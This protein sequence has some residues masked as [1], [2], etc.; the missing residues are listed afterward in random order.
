MSIDSVIFRPN[1]IKIV[2]SGLDNAGKSSLLIVMNKM[3]QFEEDLRHL[4]P[5]VRID[6]YRRDFL[7]Y[8]L[9]FWDFGGQ[10]KYRERYLQ[11]KVYFE[12][13]NQFIY[14][15]DIT[16]PNRV[17]ESLEYLGQILEILNEVGYDKSKELYIC[18]S[19]MDYNAAFSERPEYIVTLANARREILSRF[20]TFKFDFFSTSIYNVYSIVKMISKG[21]MNSIPKYAELFPIM[22]DFCQNW[23]L[24]QMVLFDNTGLII[25]DCIHHTETYDQNQLDQV[26]S[27]HLKFYK[28]LT[29]RKF[30]NF[31]TVV[32][33]TENLMNVSY[34]FNID[35]VKKAMDEKSYYISIISNLREN[36]DWEIDNLIEKMREL[37]KSIM[38]K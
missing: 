16:A 2:L 1:D 24:E 27:N 29:D 26:I 3:Y 37:L 13:I 15:I 25:A 23:N 10:S 6:Y 19:K 33:K 20:S 4:K 5:T 14:L 21:L 7:G 12:N 17:Q 32:R 36:P 38:A 30:E 34:Q 22:D 28:T 31:H 8:H 9:N 35:P 11:R 18:F